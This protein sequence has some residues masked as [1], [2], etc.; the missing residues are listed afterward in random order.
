VVDAVGKRLVEACVAGD[1]AARAQFQAQFLPLIYRFERGGDEFESASQDFI[2]FVFEDDR[3]YR[4]VRGFKGDAPLKAFMRSC[5]VPDLFK[6]FRTMIRR[7]RLQTISF[8]AA[9]DGGASIA[10][11][12]SHSATPAPPTNPAA[13]LLACLSL[14]KRVLI[15]LLYPEDFDLAPEE[16]QYLATHTGR[17][18]RDVVGRLEEARATVRSR[19]AVQYERFDAADS[20]AQWIRLHERQLARIEEDLLAFDADSPPGLRLRRKRAELWRK[21]ET[22]R[23][24]QL[25]RLQ[26]AGH[27]IVTLPTRMVAELLGQPEPTTRAQITRVRA[28]LTA[29]L[30]ANSGDRPEREQHP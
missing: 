10:G 15:K 3:V 8:D 27:T 11:T 5:I 17:E 30:S 7:Q 26:D 16:V 14:A 19:E 9:P 25:K 13:A 24:Q 21:I 2:T 12:D 22:R 4:R 29:L 23:E 18:L 1:A 28:E 20:S 6:Q